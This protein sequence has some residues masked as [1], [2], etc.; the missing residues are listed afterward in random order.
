MEVLLSEAQQSGVEFC[1]PL[2]L[3]PTLQ[4]ISQMLAGEAR[5][6]ARLGGVQR[7]ARESLSDQPQRNEG[8]FFLGKGT[9]LG[10][11]EEVLEVKNAIG[12]FLY[13]Q[14]ADNKRGEWPAVMGGPSSVA[15]SS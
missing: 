10:V 11:R 5:A 7:R 14:C 4:E 3:V 6:A 8:T 13:T 1:E 12:F 15:L 2:S 9:K